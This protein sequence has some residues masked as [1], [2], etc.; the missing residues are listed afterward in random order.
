MGA[1]FAASLCDRWEKAAR[2]FAE[3]FGSRVVYL[4]TGLVLDEGG[5]LLEP[6]LPLYKMGIG[7]AVG[8]GR[9]WMPWIHRRDYTAIVSRLLAT[10][11][12]SGPI[13]L[14]APNPVRQ[15]AFAE[16]L[17]RSLHRPH[18]M[19]TPAFA[20]RLLY[21]SMADEL[22]LGGAQVV[23]RRM[24]ELDYRFS[25]PHLREALSEIFDSQSPK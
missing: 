21:G 6:L 22:L 8:T 20:L 11:N 13:N 2:P 7:G 16:V 24:A 4:R 1:G 14:V 17:A 3:Q 10:E 23:S 18:F 9:Q 25:H 19:R 5:G 15:S 12:F